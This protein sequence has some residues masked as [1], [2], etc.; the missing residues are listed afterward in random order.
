MREIGGTFEG[1]PISCRYTQVNVTFRRA[2]GRMSRSLFKLSSGGE[3]CRTWMLTLPTTLSSSRIPH[4]LD[5]GC[6]WNALAAGSAWATQ[7]SAAIKNLC[8]RLFAAA[9][10]RFLENVRS[11][12]G[13]GD[14]RC[15]SPFMVI[16]RASRGMHNA[17]R[18]R[19]LCA[20]GARGSGR[21]VRRGD[22]LSPCV[23]VS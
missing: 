14:G 1:L 9:A 16:F 13:V 8:A 6:A 22:R 5:A 2:S 15:A 21:N 12:L 18:T 11:P 20:A 4:E 3:V 10:A 7:F 19:N 23:A 17:A